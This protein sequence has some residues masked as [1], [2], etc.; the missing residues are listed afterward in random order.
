MELWETML[1]SVLAFT[2]MM[3]KARILGKPTI[4]QMTY[5]DFVSCHYIG[6]DHREYFL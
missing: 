6:R 5:H 3:L 4:A 2:I 1:R